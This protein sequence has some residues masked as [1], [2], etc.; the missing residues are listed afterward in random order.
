MRL[1]RTGVQTY[2]VR[3]TK[4]V[5]SMKKETWDPKDPGALINIKNTLGVA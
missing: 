1:L 5:L 2:G 4:L 3:F